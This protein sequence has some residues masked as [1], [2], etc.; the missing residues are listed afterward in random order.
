MVV[1]SALLMIVILFFRKGLMGTNEF[2]WDKLINKFKKKPL[3]KEG[4]K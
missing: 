3:V 1:F 2:S 4:A